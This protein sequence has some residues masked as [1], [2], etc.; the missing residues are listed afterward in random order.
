MKLVRTDLRNDRVGL[1]LE[2]ID[3][4]LGAADR[5]ALL[6]DDRVRDREDRQSQEEGEEGHDARELHGWLD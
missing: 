6:S 2:L 1:G 3:D 4:V 5:V